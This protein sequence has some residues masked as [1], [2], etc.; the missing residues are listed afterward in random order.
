M[1]RH[2]ARDSTAGVGSIEQRLA[3]LFDSP[4]LAR[5]VPRLPPETLHQLVHARGLEACGE[6]ITSATPAQLNALLDLDLWTR[7][8]PGRDDTF[9]A[10]RFCEWVETL[11][12]AGD[13]VA[14]RAVASLDPHVMIAGLSR[15]IRVFDPGIFEP[16]AHSDDE[17]IERH[18]AMHEGDAIGV[19][20]SRHD[21]RHH[22]IE[23]EIGG[24]LVRARSADAWDAIVALLVIVEAEHPR[25]FHSL[26]QG[27]RR[28]SNSRPEASGFDDIPF[29]PEQ[30]LRDVTIER[31]RRLS[32]HGY[33]TAADA[34]AFLQM[35]RH[36]QP[37]ANAIATA[38][39]RAADEAEMAPIPAAAV[40]A[41]GDQ[42]A[43]DAESVEAVIELLAEAG[44]MPGRPRAL[45]GPA[46]ADEQPG[47]LVR[48]RRLMEDVAARDQSAFLARG[49]ELAFVANALLAGGSV[50]ARAFT[51]AEASDAAAAVCN[52]GLELRDAPESFLLDHDIMAVF[53]WGW[54]ALHRDVALFAAERLVVIIDEMHCTD[55]EVRN[56]L[57]LFRRALARHIEAGT[58]WLARD[59]A[60]VLAT[61]DVTAWA[62]VVGL[63]SECPVMPEA[64]TAILHSRS[65]HVSATAFEFIST[66]EQIHEVRHFM[67]EL[68]ALLLT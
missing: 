1:S 47:R 19:A 37:E 63:L 54:S 36:R 6:I 51:A 11:V 10:D 18:E 30:H 61:F 34:R 57:L 17:A 46:A 16:T 67:R 35:A 29:A 27:C 50:Q 65:T 33:A 5:V 32:Q 56:D 26:M 28:L 59:A 15:Y 40:L 53:E 43:A 41:A 48:L 55:R 25:C 20:P 8:Q 13:S 42:P 39:F 14:A 60:E 38:Y 31:E 12:E 9:D 22:A 49:R 7:A 58:P 44:M 68:P 45:L 52:L 21:A 24:Y 3:R 64:L 23:C 4:L 66:A 62:G 2:I